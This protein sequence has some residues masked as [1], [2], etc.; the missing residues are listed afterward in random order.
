MSTEAR[1]DDEIK[2]HVQAVADDLIKHKEIRS[3]AVIVDWDLSPQAAETMPIGVWK[4]QDKC[5]VFTGTT[6]MQIQLQKLSRFLGDILLA[7][8]HK[9]VDGVKKSE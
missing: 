2:Q 1:F 7:A 5:D 3:V 4:P 6:G 8:I 9:S